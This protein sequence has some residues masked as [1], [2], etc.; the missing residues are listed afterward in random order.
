[1]PNI[2]M[3]SVGKDRV[4]A[5]CV[6]DVA[7]ENLIKNNIECCSIEDRGQ[8]D[9][10]IVNVTDC[11]LPNPNPNLDLDLDF[12]LPPRPTHAKSR[13]QR[14]VDSKGKWNRTDT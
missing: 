6:V 12:Q 1:M 7:Q 11:F 13:R 3:T 14:S 10:I 8:T 4:C 9:R 2:R 5:L